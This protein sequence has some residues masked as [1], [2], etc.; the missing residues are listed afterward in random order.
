MARQNHT[1]SRRSG[2]PLIPPVSAWARQTPLLASPAFREELA[3]D[4]CLP[5]CVCLA[6]IAMLFGE[7]ELHC[8][9]TPSGLCAIAEKITQ[10]QVLPPLP[11]PVFDR[12]K[13]SHAVPRSSLKHE[14][15]ATVIPGVAS[16]DPPVTLKGVPECVEVTIRR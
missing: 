8:F 5:V 7:A 12:V 1:P 11:P 3:H 6:V 4:V 9:V 16:I 14:D 10:A 15:V 2:R 13:V